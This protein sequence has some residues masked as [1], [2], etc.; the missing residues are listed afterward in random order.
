MAA[1]SAMSY[2]RYAPLCTLATLAL[3]L[4]ACG[5][6]PA[7]GTWLFTNG[8]VITNTCEIDESD[9]SSG[10]FTLINNGDG[11]FT[12]DP[13]DGSEPFLC[14]LDG[15]DFICPERLQENFDLPNASIDVKVSARGIFESDTF[16]SSGRQEVTISCEGDGCGA[17]ALLFKL[18]FPCTAVVAFTASYKG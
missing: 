16:V 7:T 6:E 12:I 2:R 8:E 3:S 10:N 9:P 11:S 5:P 14:T 15:A 13:E 1:E 4:C 18:D 17:A